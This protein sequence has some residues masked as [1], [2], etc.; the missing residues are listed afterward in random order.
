MAE[1]ER[2]Y[3]DKSST[4]AI[5]PTEY[6]KNEYSC[7]QVSSSTRGK[8]KVIVPRKGEAPTSVKIAA[9]SNM[10]VFLCKYIH[11]CISVIREGDETSYTN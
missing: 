10:Y 1:E 5:I 11:P 4:S 3:A 2:I 9:L 7:I 6:N 8:G